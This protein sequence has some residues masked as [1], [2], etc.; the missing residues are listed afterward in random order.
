MTARSFLFMIPSLSESMNENASLN[1]AI[2]FCVNIAN[3]FEVLR[4]A[5]FLE[6]DLTFPYPFASVVEK[7]LS[8]NIVRLE[9][10]SR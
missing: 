10:S 5:R 4:T 9:G 1:S 7:R 8:W 2:W 6:S 3:T